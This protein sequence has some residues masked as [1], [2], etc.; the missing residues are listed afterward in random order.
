MQ[1]VITMLPSDSSA[2]QLTVAAQKPKACIHPVRGA[3]K[4]NPSYSAT[5]VM[6][7]LFTTPCFYP[8]TFPALLNLSNSEDSRRKRKPKAGSQ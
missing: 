5:S 6:R 4:G 7:S 1:Q 3:T 2:A 8:K